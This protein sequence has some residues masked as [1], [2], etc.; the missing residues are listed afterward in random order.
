[1]KLT[2]TK[3]FKNA[4]WRSIKEEQPTPE[5]NFISL[6]YTYGYQMSMY[7]ANPENSNKLPLLDSLKVE[8]WKHLDTPETDREKRLTAALEVAYGALDSIDAKAWTLA[9][10]RTCVEARNE[11]LEIIR[12]AQQQVISI[13]G[14]K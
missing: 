10:E 11:V 6:S 5:R 7:S 2:E 13:L 8:Y 4:G 14:E 12:K 1:M 9:D 3:A